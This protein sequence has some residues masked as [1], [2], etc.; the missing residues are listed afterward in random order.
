MTS[1]YTIH[2]K[3]ISNLR[4]TTTIVTTHREDGNAIIHSAENVKWQGL[5]ND[6]VV[7]NLQY[8][9]SE[10]PS[11]M[12][13]EIDIEDHAKV[14][15]A[16]PGLVNKGGSVCRTVDFSPDNEPIMHRTKSLDY[17]VVL[18]GE[19]EMILDSG[20]SKILKRGDVAVQRGTNH[21]WKNTS[22]TEW[23]RMMFVL[24]D[25]VPLYVGGVEMTERLGIGEN[26]L[27]RSNNA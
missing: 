27:P 8:T 3:P 17:G 9:T 26:N 2:D 7:F 23:A 15:E 10:F 19:M 24:L 12:N 25:S 22:K 11:Q 16:G 4:P 5:R 13:N 18:E 21:A 20:E 6:S 1:H 14:V